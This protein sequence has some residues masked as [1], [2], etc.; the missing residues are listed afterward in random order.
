MTA[1]PP[2]IRRLGRVFGAEMG[3]DWMVSHAAY[4]APVL[5]SPDRL[6]VYLVA[7]DAQGRGQVGFI[8][9]DPADPLRVLAVSPEPCLG[10][11]GLGAFDDRGISIG[12]VHQV[13]DEIR[14]Y[15]MGWNK[16][17][18]VPFRNA[19]GLA[20]AR[21]RQGLRF[22]RIFEGP[23]IDRSRFDPF[24]LSYPFVVVPSGE[25]PWTLYYGTSRAGGTDEAAM[26]HVLT[27]ATGTDGIDWRPTGETVVG[28]EPG[29]YGLSRPW[30]WQASGR[31]WMLYAI[32][33]AEYTIGLSVQEPATGAFRRVSSDLMGPGRAQWEDRASCYPALVQA[34]GRTL[35]FYNA[36]GY[37]LT[38]LGVA[39][40]TFDAA[41]T[42]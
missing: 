28:L 22:E 24:T 4:P 26:Q 40:V 23:L 33:R 17:A 12:S 8:D 7:R 6:R 34:G 21:D 29:E 42:A 18:D 35:L 13:G 14:L 5:L 36:N 31:T 3:P 9:L 39:E 41:D 37:G 30:L 38:G 27:R 32:R 25:A 15:Y 2:I 16:A 19:I 11:G 1:Q 10:P 20:V